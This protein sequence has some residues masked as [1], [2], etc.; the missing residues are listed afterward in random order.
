MSTYSNKLVIYSNLNGKKNTLLNSL[1]FCKLFTFLY[2]RH[3]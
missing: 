3:I 1:T 2:K